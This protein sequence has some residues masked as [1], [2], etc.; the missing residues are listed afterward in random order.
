MR[1]G[2]KRISR[3]TA[4]KWMLNNA[5]PSLHWNQFDYYLHPAGSYFGTK[6]GSRAEHVAYDYNQGTVYLIN[7]SVDKSG[8]RKIQV[9]LIDTNGNTLTSTSKSVQTE[10]NTSK[11]VMSVP[12]LSKIKDVGFLRL[13][14][15]DSN[16][17]VRSRNVYWLA[18]SIDQ[19]HWKKSTWFYT[20]VSDWANYTAINNMKE[21]T[22]TATV[23]SSS[24]TSLTVSLENSADIPA[25]FIRLN[26][27]DGSGADVVPVLWDDNYVT[28]FPGEK[29]ELAVSYP[30]GVGSVAVEMSGQNVGALR[31]IASR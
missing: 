22:V 30:A 12:G 25:F 29:I 14:L 7:H 1:M 31:T 19:L 20:P 24:S 21:A 4:R 3:L 8:A 11:E 13:I 17:N 9:D 15:I 23:I 6:V 16:D 18:T 10:P 26:L 27:V 28:L 5:W 2:K